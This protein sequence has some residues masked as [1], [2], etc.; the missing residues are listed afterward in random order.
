[1]GYRGGRS[2]VW[3]ED[4]LAPAESSVLFLKAA[5]P[6]QVEVAGGLFFLSP[7]RSLCPN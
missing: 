1:M 7:S 2:E 3:A 4:R 5:V 6:L